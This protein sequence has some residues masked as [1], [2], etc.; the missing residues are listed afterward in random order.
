MIIRMIWGG[1]NFG[2]PVR[3]LSELVE[4]RVSHCGRFYLHTSSRMIGPELLYEILIFEL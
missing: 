1:R 2:A 3:Y 4:S